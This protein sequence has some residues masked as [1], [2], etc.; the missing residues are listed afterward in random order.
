PPEAKIDQRKLIDNKVDTDKGSYEGNRA[1]QNA[2][3]TL[4]T[5]KDCKEFCDNARALLSKRKIPFAEKSVVNKDDIDALMKLTG[6]KEAQVPVL[7]VGS[8]PIAGFETGAWNS[9][10]DTA[11]YPKQ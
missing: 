6:T 2:P 9:A 10:L 1:A 11:G 5:S 3:V 4:Y 7:V 8:K